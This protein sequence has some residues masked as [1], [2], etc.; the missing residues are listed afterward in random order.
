MQQCL[1][2]GGDHVEQAHLSLLMNCADLCQATANFMLSA[3]TL[4]SEVCALCAK[5]CGAAAQSCKQLGDLQDC[6]EACR[7]CGESCG[8]VAGTRSPHE[9]SDDRLPATGVLGGPPRQG[10]YG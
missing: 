10:S 8:H 2:L 9:H 7:R 3:S 5:V 4:H 1:A 6:E